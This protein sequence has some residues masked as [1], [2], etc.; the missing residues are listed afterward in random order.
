MEKF[1]RRE[2][3]FRIIQNSVMHYLDDKFYHT[4]GKYMYKLDPCFPEDRYLKMPISNFEVMQYTG[5]KD[6]NG[7]EIYEGDY[8]NNDNDFRMKVG[9]VNGAFVVLN[10]MQIRPVVE[11]LKNHEIIVNIH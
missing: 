1:D 9:F 6:K 10:V 2:I 11:R 5:L 7:K 3:K 4:G 8:L